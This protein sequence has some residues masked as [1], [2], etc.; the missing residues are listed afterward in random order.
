MSDVVLVVSQV[1]KRYRLFKSPRQRLLHFVFPWAKS[2]YAT[3]DA[4]NGIDLTMHRGEALAVIGANGAGKSTL[5]KLL[6]GIASPSAGRIATNGT[7]GAIVE[8]GLGFH[9]DFSGRNNA[10]AALV[11]QGSTRREAEVQL[12]DIQQ[13]AELGDY[14]DRP[15]RTYSSGM[16]A[17][18]AFAT[19]TSIKP[20]IL[21][22][23]EVLSVGDAYFQGKSIRRIE[24]L[25]ATGTSLLFVSHDLAAVKRLC[26]RAILLSHGNLVADGPVMETLDKY[27]A[28]LASAT[29]AHANATG[30]E[31]ALQAHESILSSNRSGDGRVRVQTVSVLNEHRV[32][33][34]VLSSSAP[35]SVRVAAK[36]VEPVDEL[37]L[38]IAVRD[39]LGQTLYG[40]NTY[41]HS[42]LCRDLRAGDTVTANF[43]MRTN[44]GEGQYLVSVSAHRGAVHT[45][46]NFDWL[47]N[48][49]SFEVIN[50]GRA[51]FIGSANL[52]ARVDLDAAASEQSAP[53]AIT[54]GAK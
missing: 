23:D 13:F 44:L 34:S 25:L 33:A 54:G 42:L 38:G 40:T 48:C 8:L 53:G 47:D 1:S 11:M 2:A 5:L 52:E 26:N 12:I 22:V 28:L 17:R 9:P 41:H 36:V 16:Q 14:F 10:R 18:L 19:A 45:E 39:R 51:V 21:I 35:F 7:V 37:C 6:A 27:N 49:A 15:V 20:D 46:G 4:L 29:Q 32:A 31:P 30:A 3:H 24:T 43:N 50:P